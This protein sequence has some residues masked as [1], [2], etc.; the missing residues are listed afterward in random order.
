MNMDVVKRT[1]QV[2]RPEDRDAETTHRSE[3]EGKSVIFD[4]RLERPQVRVHLSCG[5]VCYCLAAK[6]AT[7]ACCALSDQGGCAE[8]TKRPE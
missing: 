4:V 1:T 3:R 5:L 7:R 8:V 6:C 2:V